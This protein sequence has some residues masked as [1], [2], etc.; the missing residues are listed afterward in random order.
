MVILEAQC[1]NSC[2]SGVWLALPH[3]GGREVIEGG[4]GGGRGFM[5]ARGEAT[6]RW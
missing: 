4:A 6:G 5:P 3:H 1:T 2:L